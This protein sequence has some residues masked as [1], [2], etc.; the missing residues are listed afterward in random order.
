RRGG[1]PVERIDLGGGLGIRYRAEA[2]P[3]M[4]DYAGLV[5]RITHNLGFRLAFEPGRAIVANAGVLVARTLYVKAGA[6]RCFLVLDAAM[7]DLIRPALYD[8][9]HE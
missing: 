4:A 5:R 3:P 8:A 7:N 9:W 6:T 1:L 2:P